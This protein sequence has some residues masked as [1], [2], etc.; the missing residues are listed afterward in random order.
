MPVSK[1]T[2]L[3][4]SALSLIPVYVSAETTSFAPA[5]VLAN[6]YHDDIDV[7]SYWMSEKLDGIRAIWDGSKL[8][9][10][11]GK[12]IHAP[13]WFVK[14]LPDF[15]IEGELWAGRGQFAKV[16][17]TVLDELPND[18][19]WKE[20]KFMLFDSKH[21]G[22]SYRKRYAALSAWAVQMDRPFIEMVEQREIKDKQALF[23]FLSQI[24]QQSGEGVMLRKVDA[25]YI[26]GRSD[27]LL[28][29]KKAEDTEAVVIGYKEG[30]GKYSGM[31]GALHIELGDGKKMYVGSGLTDAER[32]NPPPVGAVITIQYNGLTVTGLPRFARYQRERAPE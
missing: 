12:Q 2:P 26:S 11:S 14:D 8:L 16:Q 15:M 1:T 13:S 21:L 22:L 32:K 7:K 25:A 20:I 9:T 27:D 23:D 6:A 17:S 5:V 3:I 19:D 28:K 10:R 29:L 30:N 24:E 4:L 18:D 31:V